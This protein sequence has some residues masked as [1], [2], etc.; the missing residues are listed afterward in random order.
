M[1]APARPSPVHEKAQIAVASAR[2]AKEEAG[3]WIP[4]IS[5]PTTSE[6][7]ATKKPSFW[8]WNSDGL[9]TV[10]TMEHR[11]GAIVFPEQYT[12]ASGNVEMEAE[13]TR[14]G[15]DAYHVHQKRKTATGWETLW[16]MTLRRVGNS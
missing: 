1:P 4:T 5:P 2:G 7:A 8:Y 13:W 9:M 14:K 15:A 10:G 6:N 11:A 12:D 3:T 16:T